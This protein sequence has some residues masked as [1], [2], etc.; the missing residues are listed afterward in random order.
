VKFHQKKI[1]VEAVRL[2]VEM[3]L[4]MA[5]NDGTSEPWTLRAVLGLRV[6]DKDGRVQWEKQNGCS[7]VWDKIVD[8]PGESPHW[9]LILYSFT[10][11]TVP[12]YASSSYCCRFFLSLGAR[13]DVLTWYIASTL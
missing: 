6:G 3:Q 12:H 9:T 5:V 8:F 10:A 7:P 4:R 2:L 11:F 13:G 1:G